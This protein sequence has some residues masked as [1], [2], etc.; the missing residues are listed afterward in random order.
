M[1]GLRAVVFTDV[2]Q[3][4]ILFGGA[5]LVLISVTV[6]L[7]GVHV[8]WPTQWHTNWDPLVWGFASDSHRTFGWFFLA[9]LVWYVCTSGS[10]QMAIQRFLATRDAQAARRVMLATLIS[11]TLVTFILSLVGLALLAYFRANPHVLGDGQTIVADADQLLP[12][13]I[14]AVLPPGISGLVVAGLLAAAMSSLSSGVNSSCS[15]LTEDF[16]SRLKRT[17]LSETQHIR[18]AKWISVIVGAVVVGI[19]FFVSVVPGNLLEI[20]YRVV[21]L[22]VAPLFVLFCLAMFVPRA[23]VFA[24]WISTACSVSVAVLISFW[25]PFFGEPGPSF[26]YIMPASLVVGIAVGLL[27]GYIPIGPKARPLLETIE[28]E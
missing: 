6:S 9:S 7:G 22:L 26:L 11:L 27:A 24:A 3:S 14:V 10:D 13:Y 25:E 21:N 8:W 16:I 20:C 18:L 23:T 15:V 17:S 5:L 4:L 19:S 28:E 2:A 12:R 1:G